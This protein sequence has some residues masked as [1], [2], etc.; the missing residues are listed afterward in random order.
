MTVI[1]V[2]TFHAIGLSS[3]AKPTDIP[4]G[5]VFW[6][7]DSQKVY[8]FAQGEWKET[9]SGS[10]VWSASSPETLTNKTIILNQ[11]VVETT[12]GDLGVFAF[13]SSGQ[14]TFVP[15]G[16]ANQYFKVNS[17]AS[18]FEWG[19]PSVSGSWDPNSP[20]TLTQ[21]T[22]RAE[23]NTFTSTTP[24]AGN[25]LVDSGTKYL[26]ITKGSIGQALKVKSDGT[27]GWDTDQTGSSLYSGRP[28]LSGWKEGW[29][30]GGATNPQLGVDAQGVLQ[31]NLWFE[32]YSIDTPDTATSNTY[33][34]YV[35]L[36]I[37][38]STSYMQF[39]SYYL[40]MRNFSSHL[41]CKFRRQS[42]VDAA[43]LIGFTS[44]MPA[45]FTSY[46]VFNNYDA[47]AFGKRTGYTNWRMFHNAATATT[48]AD[49]IG[50]SSDTN[51]HTIEIKA[52]P[53]NNRW[54]WRLH[55]TV[56]DNN[57][58]WNNITTNI[59]RSD[60]PLGLFV[61]INGYTTGANALE[62]YLLEAMNKVMF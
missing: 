36:P 34:R 42:T 27:V 13:N 19:D 40:F 38:A 3:D 53:S 6:E 51:P 44:S 54:Q 43:I 52:D 25:I 21:K 10:G 62:M 24:A 47:I 20:E 14:F 46:T 59:P 22:L 2:H 58:A 39:K 9:K 12:S 55:N 4:E 56:F 29:Y 26:P 45:Q 5:M 33:G 49:D 57:A 37:S 60:I 35:Y 8:I 16:S 18:G 15:I 50:V 30:D 31:N 11:N 48:S 17:G 28:S 32:Y 7:L 41:L 61:S 23:N 1:F